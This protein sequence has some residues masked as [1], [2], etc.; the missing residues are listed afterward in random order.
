[1]LIKFLKILKKE[2]I[3]F[4]LT[5]GSLLGAVRQESFA[6]KP[7]DVDLG[8]RE[9][10]LPR[11]LKAIPLLIKNGAANIRRWP[12]NRTKRLQIFFPFTLIDVGIYKKKGKIWVGET[13]NFYDKKFKGITF[14]IKDLENLS[15]VKAYGL[16]FLAPANPE[17]YLRKKFGKNWKTPDKKQFFWNKKKIKYKF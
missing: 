1:M 6:G 9:E 12:L 2:E 7:S 5:G 8:I 10:Q 16:K 3:S 11:L 14:P 15:Y 4:F 17:T 13:E